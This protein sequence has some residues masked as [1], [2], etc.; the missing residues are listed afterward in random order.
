MKF[1]KKLLMV[2]LIGAFILP[3]YSAPKKEKEEKK[4]T[5]IECPN[6]GKK[7][8]LDNKKKSKK[9]KSK[10]KK[11]KK[12]K[13]KK[14]K[15]AKEVQKAGE[16]KPAEPASIKC[17][18]CKKDIPLPGAEKKD[19]A[20]AGEKDSEKNAEKDSENSAETEAGAENAENSDSENSAE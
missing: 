10:K 18:K 3:V 4:P 13:G 2:L 1:V 12:K 5:S 14:N 11:N 8:K 15:D 6:C 19:K 20:A 7:V 9:K 17:P 16:K